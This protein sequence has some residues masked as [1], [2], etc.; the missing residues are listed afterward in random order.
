MTNAELIAYVR[1]RLGDPVIDVELDNIQIQK[2]IDE[3]LRLWGQHM[4]TEKIMSI[5]IVAGQQAYDLSGVPGLRG[6]TCLAEEPIDFNS[7]VEFDIFRD[8]VWHLPVPNVTDIA[9]DTLYLN[10]LRYVGS[11]QFDWR[12]E[13]STKMLYVSP[14]PSRSYKAF[15]IY[16]TSPTLEEATSK[17]NWVVEMT[18]AL[19]KETLGYIRRKHG[20]KV[21]GRE[22]EIP[23]DG[24]TLIQEAR[25]TIKELMD[26]LDNVGGDWLPP[27]RA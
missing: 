4:P 11:T 8:R 12:Y 2:A 15:A 3:A 25:E 19:A 9:I 17:Y 18:M 21:P 20:D 5:D 10:T 13:E 1:T 7:S 22:L 23:L 27:L 16:T 6:I 14:I 24:A 26:K